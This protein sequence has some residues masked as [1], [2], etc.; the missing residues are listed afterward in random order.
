MRIKNYRSLG[1]L[2]PLTVPS[3]VEENDQLANAGET[4]RVN[5]T[6]ED[7]VD[8]VVYRSSLA[9][10][11]DLFCEAVEAST[12]IKRNTKTL[13]KEDG[14]AKKDK[15]GNDR[16]VYTESEAEFIDRVLATTGRTIESFEEL[17]NTVVSKVKYDPTASERGEAGPKTPPKSVFE[18]VDALISAGQHTAVAES[19]KSILG[20]EVADDRESLAK[21]IHED[22]LNEIRKAKNKF[23]VKA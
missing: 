6:L 18:Q 13:T 19:L 3:T 8:N 17:K 16:T 21:A 10:F 1:M 12:G 20:R 5:P 9:D 4:K 14:T 23:A 11:R 7:A 2:I 15:D 22:Q